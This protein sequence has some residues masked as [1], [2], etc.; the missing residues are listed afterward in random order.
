MQLP[1]GGRLTDAPGALAFT[2][3][4]AYFGM[5]DVVQ[6]KAGDFV[7]VLGTGRTAGAAEYQMALNKSQKRKILASV[8]TPEKV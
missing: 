2:G 4:T 1:D 7:V 8:G 3:F 5:I 6:I